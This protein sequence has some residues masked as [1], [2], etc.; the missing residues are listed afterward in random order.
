MSKGIFM[1][2][3]F[4]EDYTVKENATLLCVDRDTS[5]SI[6]L[7][8]CEGLCW[9][10]SLSSLFSPP[11]STITSYSTS[12]PAV[13]SISSLLHYLRTV[14]RRLAPQQ[15]PSSSQGRDFLGVGVRPPRARV[16][17]ERASMEDSSEHAQDPG[18]GATSFLCWRYLF[19]FGNWVTT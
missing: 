1:I 19:G 10:L 13:A 18:A 5:W 3:I 8:L 12:R 15:A 9:S 16:D 7:D 11:R 4:L 14:P 6:S 17:A 2:Y